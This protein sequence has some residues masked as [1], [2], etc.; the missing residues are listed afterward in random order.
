MTLSHASAQSN[1]LFFCCLRSGNVD[2]I[3]VLLAHGADPSKTLQVGSSIH[4]H[5]SS[6]YI[7]LFA[8]GKRILLIKLLCRPS[9]VQHPGEIL[10]CWRLV[11]LRT[12]SLDDFG[13]FH[14]RWDGKRS[15]DFCGLILT[16][17]RKFPYNS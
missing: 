2:A 8:N 16:I 15:D 6:Y 4:L 17:L 9:W 11:G 14:G 1:I 7:S 3:K 13:S 5:T 10:R 12:L